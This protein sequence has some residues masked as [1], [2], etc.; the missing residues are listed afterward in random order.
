M[1]EQRLKKQSGLSPWAVEQ[2]LDVITYN[3]CS[4]LSTQPRPGE[5]RVNAV[6]ASFKNERV[7]GLP[8]VGGKNT[9]ICEAG[10]ALGLFSGA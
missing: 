2:G 4:V 3:V 9:V 8:R 1:G 5:C 7:M 10:F 6:L